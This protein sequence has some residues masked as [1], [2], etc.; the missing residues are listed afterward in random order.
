MSTM[1][2]GKGKLWYNLDVPSLSLERIGQ[3]LTHR[4]LTLV[5]RLALGGV[6]I[7]AGAAKLGQLQGFIHIVYEYQIL[8]YYSFVQIYGY[9]LPPLEVALGVFL[10]L[11]LLLR[12]SSSVFILVI[13]SFVIAKSVALA[14][15]MGLPCGCFGEVAVMLGSQALALDLFLLALAFQILFHRGEFLSLGPWLKRRRALK[16]TPT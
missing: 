2:V 14:R 7:F 15:G 3:F 16:S 10:V 8:P 11:G 1:R 12:I 5:T 9:V 6:F 4:Y 13:I